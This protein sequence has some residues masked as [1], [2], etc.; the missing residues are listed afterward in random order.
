[1]NDSSQKPGN[2]QIENSQAAIF[3]QWNCKADFKEKHRRVLP[4]IS[5]EDYVYVFDLPQPPPG[6]P[7][8]RQCFAWHGVAFNPGSDGREEVVVL[9]VQVPSYSPSP[10]MALWAWWTK[11][12][13]TDNEADCVVEFGNWTA[14]KLL[15]LHNLNVSDQNNKRG[16]F[17]VRQWKDGKYLIRILVHGIKFPSQT[18]AM[19]QYRLKSVRLEQKDIETITEPIGHFDVYHIAMSFPRQ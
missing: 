17:F 10:L 16:K 13:V 7:A 15:G 4:N 5:G 1:M 2:G 6:H 8:A 12:L 14:E 3:K 11:D 19:P 9:D 18:G